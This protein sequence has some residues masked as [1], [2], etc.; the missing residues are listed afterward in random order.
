MPGC[1]TNPLIPGANDH[2][3]DLK[4]MI[5]WILKEVDCDVPIHFTAFHPD[6][7]M[8]NI[9]ATSHET[10]SIAYETAMQAGLH[11]V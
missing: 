8:Q 6:F 2:P 11:C 1:V 3:D 4:R 7:H 9:P 5:D 10:L